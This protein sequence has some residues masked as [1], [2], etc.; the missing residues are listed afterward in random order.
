MTG[1]SVG[2][3]GGCGNDGGV[4]SEPQITQIFADGL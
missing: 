1:A 2:M 4:S 3:T